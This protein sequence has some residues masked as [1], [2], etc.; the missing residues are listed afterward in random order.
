MT[1]REVNGKTG[2]KVGVKND[3]VGTNPPNTQSLGVCALGE[4][5]PARP[6]SMQLAGQVGEPTEMTNIPRRK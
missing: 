5:L 1:L 2:A 4:N 3:G 6:L